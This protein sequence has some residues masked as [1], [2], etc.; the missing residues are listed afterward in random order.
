MNYNEEG[1]VSM[2]KKFLILALMLGLASASYGKVIGDWEN[3]ADMQGWTGG[4]E[5]SPYLEI[6]TGPDGDATHLTPGA[7]VTSGSHALLFS[8][9][10]KYFAL[11]YTAPWS[12]ELGRNDIPEIGAGTKLTMDVTLWGADMP[13]WGKFAGKIAINSDGA[14]GWMEL[15]VDA[16]GTGSPVA[17]N[18]DGGAAA[19]D[20]GPWSGWA[21]AA[22][23]RHF[24]ITLEDYDMTGATWFQ[25]NFAAQIN[26]DTAP[27][28]TGTLYIDNVQIIPEPATIAMLGLGGLALIRRK[29]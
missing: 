14:S 28:N 23:K 5:G 12:S 24:E 29:K 22:D 6:S 2:C 25:I 15:G 20:F 19:F 4:W 11:Q 18:R 17:T 26:P 10:Q 16:G 13:D 1:G 7:A 9:T 21:G 27:F 3:G 8:W